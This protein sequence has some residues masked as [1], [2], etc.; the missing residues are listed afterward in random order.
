M[1]ETDIFHFP[2][3]RI[4]SAAER[5]WRDEQPIRLTAKVFAVLRYLVEHAGQLVTRDTIFDTVWGN[6]SVSEAALSSCI[7]DIRRALEDHTPPLRFLETVRGRGYRFIAPVTVTQSHILSPASPQAERLT[8]RAAPALVGRQAEIDLLL[9]WY[10]RALQGERQIVF[11]TGEA[12]IGKTTIVDALVAHLSAQEGVWIGHGQCV[13]H[14]GTGEAY[15]PLFTILGQLGR[16]PSGPYLIEQLQKYAPNW[17]LQMP[18]LIPLEAF[19]SLQRRTGGI[20]QEHM[21]RELVEAV[22]SLTVHHPLVVVLEDLHWCDLSTLAWLTYVARR[23]QPARL[24][25]IGTYRPVDAAARAHPVRQVA[26]ELQTWHQGTELALGY[27]TTEGVRAY[28]TQRFPTADVPSELVPVLQQRTN[29][30]PLFLVTMVDALVQRGV[31]R[32]HTTGWAFSGAL[33][34][35]GGTVP[36]GLQQVIGQQME[37]LPPAALEL[38]EAASVAGKEFAA[39]TLWTGSEPTLD[40][41]EEQ[42]ATLARRR[43]FVSAHGVDK[44]PDGT[45]STR[46]RFLH[47]LYRDAAYE[48]LAAGQRVWWH[49]HIGERLE[50][51]YGDQA[52]DIAVE[53][54]S[55]FVQGQDHPRAVRYLHDAGQRA[56]HRAAHQ[57]AL[58][59]LHQAL[60]LLVALPET[61]ERDQREL[62]L[63]LDLASALITTLGYGAGEVQAAYRRAQV[64]CQKLEA[65]PRLLTILIGL[66]IYYQ[67]R[68]D[69]HQTQ[70]L[71]EQL[72]QLAPGVQDPLLFPTI[73]RTCGTTQLYLGNLLAA[74]RYLEEGVALADAQ[75]QNG[76]HAFSLE[77]A[78]VTNRSNLAWVLW[79]LGY[80]EQALERD[81]QALHLARQLSQS[82]GLARALLWSGRLYHFCR[83]PTLARQQAEAAIA[84][85]T[86]QGFQFSLIMGLMLRGWAL[87]EHGQH[88]AGIAQLHQGLARREASEVAL[89]RSCYLTMLADAYGKQGDYAQGLQVLEEALAFVERSQERYWEAEIY[90][91]QGCLLQRG[92]ATR[93]SEMEAS[94]QQA[95]AIAREQQAKSL[96][97]RA[98]MS[99]C[100]LWQQQGKQAAAHAL[101]APLYT[102]FR[103]G[104]ETVDMQE[105]GTLLEAL[106]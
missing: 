14:Y 47:D 106:G 66:A 25:I 94:F 39:A 32:Q 28:L 97:L 27:L 37:Q 85:V 17:L 51:G 4:D 77:D 55:Y 90:R 42:F 88:E 74:R 93:Q 9:Q 67:V 12:G 33:E 2:P 86:A 48:R 104:L 53:L 5:L 96:E 105:A 7:R 72:L 60:E 99:L 38:L 18:A 19:E 76:P 61:T 75:R 69:F 71:T 8:S 56:L 95:I 78:G 3:F 13:E 79:L 98:T 30:N 91:L 73:Y 49:R 36:E 22:E 102:W 40:T 45:V 15:L 44:W 41:I 59:H 34:A 29:G 24:F 100:R 62:A 11:L 89:S 92:L 54:A 10:T 80:P 57:E 65:T 1:P 82:Y 68:A 103:E 58:G 64:L 16:G 35:V 81:A 87:V 26:Q 20:T 52:R 101:L 31:V 70:E 63:L 6:S 50:K 83:Q 84:L 46:Y 21:L 23:R 43:Q